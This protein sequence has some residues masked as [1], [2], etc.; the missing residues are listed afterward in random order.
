MES[1]ESD[2]RSLPPTYKGI[3]FQDLEYEVKKDLQAPLMQ[4]GGNRSLI[5]RLFDRLKSS[6]AD[7]EPYG[8]IERKY[9]E[10]VQNKE[11]KRDE[12]NELLLRAEHLGPH[13]VVA[14]TTDRDV[15]NWFSN[16]FESLSITSGDHHFVF[17]SVPSEFVS[18]IRSDL[19]PYGVQLE[20]LGSTA[21]KDFLDRTTQTLERMH[22]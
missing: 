10:A 8:R 3:A 5:S 20:D 18:S 21:K 11:R 12:L 19:Q 4:G 16:Q 22:L 9:Q 1:L 14:K 13:V 6:T 15:V 17:S 7:P 2:F